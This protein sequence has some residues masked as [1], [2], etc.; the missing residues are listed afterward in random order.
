MDSNQQKLE[1]L[2]KLEVKL[3]V[4]VAII[5]MKKK[6]VCSKK[7]QVTM[8]DVGNDAACS[9]LKISILTSVRVDSSEKQ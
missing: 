4:T 9:P 2:S 5:S 1:I 6:K 7:I 8:L 3:F